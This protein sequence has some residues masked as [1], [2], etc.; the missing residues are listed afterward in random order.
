MANVQGKMQIGVFFIYMFSNRALGYFLSM[1]NILQVITFLTLIFVKI[2]ESMSSLFMEMRH[3]VTFD[4]DVIFSLF[5]DNTLDDLLRYVV[6]E[7]IDKDIKANLKFILEG[8]ET[9]YS[10]LG[11]RAN[12]FGV[13]ILIIVKFYYCIMIKLNLKC[14]KKRIKKYKSHIEVTFSQLSLVFVETCLDMAI[15]CSIELIIKDT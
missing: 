6:P 12:L 13:I 15:V 2:P 8:V 4:L 5:G 9:Q 1:A 11:L 14:F 3:I 7:L 10:L